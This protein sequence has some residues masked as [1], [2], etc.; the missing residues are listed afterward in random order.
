[1]TKGWIDRDDISEEEEEEEVKPKESFEPR[2]LK[3]V[4]EED[5]ERDEEMDDFEHK[6]N[7]R[8]EEP[9]AFEIKCE[10]II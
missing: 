10:S 2:I 9:G 5:S 8:F 6:Y 4:D 1:M 7:F 3:L